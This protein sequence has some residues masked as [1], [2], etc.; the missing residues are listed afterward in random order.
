[1]EETADHVDGLLAQGAKLPA[2][3][4]ELFETLKSRGATQRRVLL[5]EV[6]Q[7]KPNYKHQDTAQAAY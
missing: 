4:A 7:I 5:R 6:E 3:T 2:Q 1:M